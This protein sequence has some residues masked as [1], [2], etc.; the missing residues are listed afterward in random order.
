MIRRESNGRILGR[1]SE[2]FN[3]YNAKDDSWEDYKVSDVRF[4]VHS[5]DKI[6]PVTITYIRPILN[7]QN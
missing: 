7:T 4:P 1:V 6:Y 5:E 2:W 3:H